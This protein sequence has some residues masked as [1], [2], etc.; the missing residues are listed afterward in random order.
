MFKRIRRYFRLRRM[1]QQ[2]VLETL[3]TI[4]LYL[5][6]DGHFARNSYAQYMGGHFTRL[7]KLS[8]SLREGGTSDTE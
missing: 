3:C 5:E 6:R 1:I 7:K 2:E 8:E 4:C